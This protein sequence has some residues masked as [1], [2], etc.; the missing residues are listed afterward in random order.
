MYQINRREENE[1]LGERATTLKLPQWKSCHIWT[2]NFTKKKDFNLKCT[3]P[4]DDSC[5]NESLSTFEL[6]RFWCCTHPS[7]RGAFDS[8]KSL[9]NS[10]ILFSSWSVSH[11]KAAQIKLRDLPYQITHLYNSINAIC[12]YQLKIEL[13]SPVRTIDKIPTTANPVPYLL[14]G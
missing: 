2:C 5:S 11:F 10:F 8:F 1:G 9:S 14:A 6:M 3:R 12:E 4:V 13:G 7:A